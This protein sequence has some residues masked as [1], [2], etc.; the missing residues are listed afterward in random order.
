MV[1]R[2]LRAV[3]ILRGVAALGVVFAHLVAVER[4]YLPGTPLTPPGLEVGAAGVDLFFVISGFIMTTLTLGRPRAPGDTR[5]FLF[6]RVTRIYP[7]YWI[8]FALI[9]PLFLLHPE[10]VNSHHGRPDLLTSFLLIPDRHLPLLIVAWT[11][12]YELYFYLVFAAIYRF[13]DER[14]AVF[15]LLAW[16]AVVTLGNLALSG[17]SDDPVLH[18]AF[19]PLTLEFIAGCFVARLIPRAGRLASTLCLAG[20]LAVF[21]AGAFTVGSAPTMQPELAWTRAAVFGVAAALLLAGAVG[22]ESATRHAPRLSVD[23]GD[24][25]YSLYLAHVLVIGAVGWLWQHALGS[26]SLAN[27]LLM[28]GACVVA[29]VVWSRLSFRFAERP[30]IAMSRHALERLESGFGSRTAGLAMAAVRLRHRP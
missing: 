25:S 17:G 27:H 10:M 16:A 15:G 12:S 1:Q 6:R 21:L 29:A 24:A 23:I 26:P 28:V 3:Q 20:G 22:W 9:L 18:V 7:L 5:R 30:L 14:Q 19:N 2:Q 4:K 8:Y 11:L 13:L